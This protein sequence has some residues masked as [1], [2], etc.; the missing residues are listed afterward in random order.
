MSHPKPNFERMLALIDEVFATR[1]DP[2]Q[3]QV[4]QKQ[5]KKLQAIHEATLSEYADE[6]GPLIWILLIPVTKQVMTDF[7]DDK[8][9]ETQLLEQ[10]KPGEKY[11]AIYLCS[12]TTLP[13]M[14]GKGETKKLCLKA[15]GSIRKDHRITS[16]LVWPFTKEG[17]VLAQSIASECGLELL[18]KE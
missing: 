2:G 1:N 17:E 13:E 6:N 8:I 3:I 18:V 7:L 4:S 15:I 12:A 10:T 5:M 14:R 11:D 16:L 9:S